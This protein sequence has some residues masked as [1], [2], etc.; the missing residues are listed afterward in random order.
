MRA[1]EAKGCQGGRRPALAADKTGAVRTAYLENRSI[2][3]LARGHGVS[4][5][6]IR[7]AVADLLPDH[8]AV[9]K[10]APAPELPVTLDI[11]GKAVYFLRTAELEPAERAAL[12][13]GVTVRRGQGYT[14]RVTAITAVHRQLLDR[15]Q[16]LD[17][18]QGL[19]AVPAQRK[20]RREYENRVSALT[21]YP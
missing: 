8:T 16:P 6:A 12:D 19:P 15:C 10:D 3:A 17:G 13:Q 9:E 14:L 21:P 2:A 18:G 5:G 11:P 7:T 20:A 4:R 1:T